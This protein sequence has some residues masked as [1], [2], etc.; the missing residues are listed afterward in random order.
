[1]KFS[2]GFYRGT[3]LAHCGVQRNTAS[4]LASTKKTE[5]KWSTSMVFT[6][7][8]CKPP[9]LLF[10]LIRDMRRWLCLLLLGTL[11]GTHALTIDIKPV[12]LSAGQRTSLK[13]FLADA[14]PALTFDWNTIEAHAGSIGR[15][16]EPLSATLSTVSALTAAGLCRSEQHR[17]HFESGKGRWHAN[18]DLTSLLA[19]RA[20]GGDCATAPPPVPIIVGK[21]LSDA[22]IL[23]IA[24]ES[25]ALRGRAAGVIGGSDCARV[26]F[27]A[28]TLRRIDRVKQ[29]EP[30]RASRVLTTLTYSPLQPGPSC[31]YVMEVSFVGPLNDL[32]PLGASCPLP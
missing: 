8:I 18:D 23:F 12:K 22:E 2:A 15:K 14:L 7:S 19:W 28:V 9:H 3:R 29:E 10:L 26:R 11:T 4:I 13:H 1:M 31:L 16:R 25:D 5:S 27:C 17:F 20:Q 6:V 30:P 32:V 24:R 21:S